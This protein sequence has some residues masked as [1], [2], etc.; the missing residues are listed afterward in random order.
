M[1]R[2]AGDFHHRPL[3]LG[4]M[5]TA[6]AFLVTGCASSRPAAYEVPPSDPLEGFNRAM[7][8]VNKAGDKAIVRP[9]AKGYEFITPDPVEKGVSNFFSNINSPVSI[10]NNLLQGKFK[11]AFTETSRLVL[12]STLGLGGIFDPATDA[13]I[14]E[15]QEGFGQTLAV[16]GVKPG[17]Y[18]VLPFFGP[19]SVRDGIGSYADFRTT[20]LTY[21]DNS[22]VRDKL[23]ILE[24]ISLRASLLP[25]DKQLYGAADPYL[26]LRNSWVQNRNF[27][28]FDG[29]PPEQNDD[30]DDFGGEFDN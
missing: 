11:G 13:G 12:N 22:S 10:L 17:P 7:F 25:L 19:S 27:K 9:L 29:N 30:D 3:R 15:R 24:L 18:L 26:F 1:T 23:R 16:W 21:Y 20:P 5:I 6:L 8:A 28:I 2:F 4:L 14:E